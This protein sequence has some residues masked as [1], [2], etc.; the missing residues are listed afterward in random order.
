VRILGVDPGSHV[1]GWGLVASEP[2]GLQLLESDVIRIGAGIALSDGLALLYSRLESVVRRI[3]PTA[4]A[5]E[6]PFHGV[7]ARSALRLAHARGVVLAVLGAAAIPVAEY[8]PATVKKSVTGDGRAG[9]E[10]VR[11]MVSHLL[12]RARLGGGRDLSDAL[13]VALCHAAIAP[14]L[15]ALRRADALADRSS[16]QA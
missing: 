10:Q 3:E 9:K 11:R 5:V 12:G 15:E 4:A 7:N 6:A 2:S 16:R 1:T 14:R 8:T 13:A